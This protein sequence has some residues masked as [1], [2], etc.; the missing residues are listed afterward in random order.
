MSRVIACL[1]NKLSKARNN[2]TIICLRLFA[3]L[4][5][6]AIVGCSGSEEFIEHQFNNFQKHTSYTEDRNLVTEANESS[7][8]INSI[9][10]KLTWLERPSVF[11]RHRWYLSS[12]YDPIHPDNIDFS[13]VNSALALDKIVGPFAIPTFGSFSENYIH[14]LAS[15]EILILRNMRAFYHGGVSSSYLKSIPNVQ[16][17]L[18][19]WRE[20]FPYRNSIEFFTKNLP[21]YGLV[22]FNNQ[23]ILLLKKGYTYTSF[24]NN[25][26]GF[27]PIEGSI[28]LG[29]NQT[30]TIGP[31]TNHFQSFQSFDN[32]NN[33]FFENINLPAPHSF[34]ESNSKRTYMINTYLTISPDGSKLAAIRGRRYL[35][36]Y[37]VDIEN[38]TTDHFVHYSEAQVSADT[39]DEQILYDI[40]GSF[41]DRQ[42]NF[43]L[44]DKAN[45]KA[46]VYNP[47]SNP[48]G[49]IAEIKNIY[50]KDKSKLSNLKQEALN[51]QL[52]IIN[53]KAGVSPS[54]LYN[55]EYTQLSNNQD[56]HSLQVRFIDR[57]MNQEFYSE[58]IPIAKPSPTIQVIHQPYLSK[59]FIWDNAVGNEMQK[60]LAYDY[61][62]VFSLP[63]PSELEWMEENG[64]KDIFE[65]R[66]SLPNDVIDASIPFYYDGPVQDGL[67]HGVGNAVTDDGQWALINSEFE[68]GVLKKGTLIS[69]SREIYTGEFDPEILAAPGDHEVSKSTYTYI[70][71]LT[72]FGMKTDREG[73]VYRGEFKNGKLNGEGEITFTSGRQQLGEFV[74][75]NLDGNGKVIK[76]D[77]TFMQGTFRD[78][79]PHGELT[80]NNKDGNIQTYVFESGENV[81]EEYI[82]QKE[83]YEEKREEQREKLG[84]VYKAD[85]EQYLAKQERKAKLVN[86]ALF[87]AAMGGM[88]SSMG[89]D[90]LTALE[91]GV[92]AFSDSYQGTTSNLQNFRPT[93]QGM[94]NIAGGPDKLIDNYKKMEA[95]TKSANK[96]GINVADAFGWEEF[97]EQISPIL[98]GTADAF[99]GLS[100]ERRQKLEDMYGTSDMEET[101]EGQSSGQDS[102]MPDCDSGEPLPQGWRCM[103]KKGIKVPMRIDAPELIGRWGEFRFKEGGYI[104]YNGDGT[105]EIGINCSSG[106]NVSQFEWGIVPQKNGSFRNQE[107]WIIIHEGAPTQ[108]TIGSY[109]IW[110]GGDI[111]DGVQNG[112][113][114]IKSSV[115]RYYK[116]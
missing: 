6:I 104:T 99:A 2:K 114:L 52:R 46:M 50:K 33:H 77:D 85:Y 19:G 78:G 111:E 89:A 103:E 66:Q 12:K 37:I 76:D 11:D 22:N 38:K 34:Y 116:E 65:K 58:I 63:F 51:K 86:S 31:I 9:G 55:I 94:N 25:V 87:G 40:S 44:L 20:G 101:T 28:S 30:L 7:F 110:Q 71:L 54:K 53:K 14:S 8:V 56:E 47:Q 35:D 13:I 105:G 73:N 98:S 113:G 109:Q 93:L 72:G 115:N 84:E 18:G 1:P 75:D 81:D 96:M 15:G 3:V 106:C 4:T 26:Y 82:A 16:E 91:F 80:Y 79:Q 27:N 60:M 74:N 57:M 43:Y 92:A 61:S 24:D 5:F 107:K 69:T 23:N 83:K 97:Q 17:M 59:I 48:F 42:N 36:I 90:D 102:P 67:A 64:Y 21:S 39:K 112:D 108:L 100:T 95:F 45:D 70:P 10:K 41:F 29:E 68:K 62:K 88:A 32:Q 49:A